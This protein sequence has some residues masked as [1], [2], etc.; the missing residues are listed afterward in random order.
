M[1][2]LGQQAP[3]LTKLKLRF[4]VVSPHKMCLVHSKFLQTA[5]ILAGLFPIQ[6]LK[7]HDDAA[8]WLDGRG[9]HDRLRCT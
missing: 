2:P 6:D 9:W 7:H 3:F 4:Q 1:T 5:V 8:N